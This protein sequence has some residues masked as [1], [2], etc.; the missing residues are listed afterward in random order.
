MALAF[1]FS[2]TDEQRARDLL[3]IHHVVVRAGHLIWFSGAGTTRVMK[4]AYLRVSAR[5]RIRQGPLRPQTKGSSPL[6]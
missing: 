5:L 6:G 1:L 3:S 2:A 4:V